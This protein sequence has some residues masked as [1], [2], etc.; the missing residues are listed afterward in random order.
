ML[1]FSANMHPRS[2]SKGISPFIPRQTAF[3]Q[4]QQRD[5]SLYSMPNC[6]LAAPAKGFFPLFQAKQPS[7]SSSKGIFPFISRQT[8]FSQLQQRDFSLYFMP[9]CL[10]AAPAKGFFPLFHAKLP[11]RSSSK[12]IFPFILD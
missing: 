3:S 2:S 1:H 6:L 7:R 11:T 12:G 4:L 9:N 10:L 5:F 8:A